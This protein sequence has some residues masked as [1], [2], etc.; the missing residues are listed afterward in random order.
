[1]DLPVQCRCLHHPEAPWAEFQSALLLQLLSPPYR[2]VRSHNT[3]VSADFSVFS[4]LTDRTSFA[5]SQRPSCIKPLSK[6]L[7]RRIN[8]V[9]SSH[10]GTS[11]PFPPQQCLEGKTFSHLIGLEVVDL[12]FYSCGL[13]N[14]AGHN[15]TRRC[16]VTQSLN[17]SPCP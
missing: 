3:Y 9:D 1:M 8:L 5:L 4:P 13:D 17:T 7:E 11:E 14:S 12:I 6:T 15:P 2:C 10:S 16:A